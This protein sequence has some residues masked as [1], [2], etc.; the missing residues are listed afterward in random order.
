[1]LHLLWLL[2][3][4]LK[5]DDEGRVHIVQKCSV[6]TPKK[7]MSGIFQNSHRTPDS[8]VSLHV[9][10]SSAFYDQFLFFFLSLDF[11]GV[12]SVMTS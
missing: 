5:S 10:S 1:M 4:A 2:A 7:T 12:F 9:T 3:V 8:P 6:Y 11:R